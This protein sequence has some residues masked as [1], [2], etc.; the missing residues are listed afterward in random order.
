MS[1]SLL[2]MFVWLVPIESKFSF[3]AATR[4][5]LSVVSRFAMV[6]IAPAL[7]PIKILSD[8]LLTAL[9]PV[10]VS[11]LPMLVWLVAI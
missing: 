8:V 9:I 1:V 7:V 4:L 5:L 11:L 3:T 6:P 2:P 10:S